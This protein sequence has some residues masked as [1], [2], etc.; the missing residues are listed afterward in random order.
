LL[1][2]A[3]SAVRTHGDRP[4][5]SVVAVSPLEIGRGGAEDIGITPLLQ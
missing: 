3:L 2:F 5:A 4:P 1:H